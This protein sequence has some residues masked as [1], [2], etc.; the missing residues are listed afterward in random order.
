MTVFDT[1]VIN[2][3]LGQTWANGVLAVGGCDGEGRIFSRLLDE[4]VASQIGDHCWL[5]LNE[6]I[7][8]LAAYD[9]GETHS[10]WV[11][12]SAIILVGRRH[13]GAWAGIVTPR[14]LS[15]TLAKAVESRLAQ[16]V[17]AAS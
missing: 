9:C 2:A 13:D 3:W 6:A 14:E 10:C 11:F 8:Q 15:E 12:E 4:K 1:E 16:F 17:S 7:A 5:V